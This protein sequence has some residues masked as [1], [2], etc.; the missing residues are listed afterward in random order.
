MSAISIIFLE[1]QKFSRIRR[2][3]FLR[4]KNIMIT[5][6]NHHHQQ[7]LFGE[8]VM[9]V[10]LARCCYK[11]VMRTANGERY[12]KI[13]DFDIIWSWNARNWVNFQ[14]VVQHI[15]IFVV[16]VV[17]FLFTLHSVDIFI[18]RFTLIVSTFN[19]DTRVLCDASSSSY[20]T[21]TR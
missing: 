9:V 20:E 12:Q 11:C 6:C 3:L 18:S 17:V 1:C 14:S 16:V 7:W 13:S 4:G 10:F 19:I 21:L 8:Y 5:M 2:F 15:N